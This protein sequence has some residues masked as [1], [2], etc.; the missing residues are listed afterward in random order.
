MARGPPP[1]GSGE[2]EEEA[3]GGGKVN[4]AVGGQGGGVGGLG[5]LRVVSMGE[6]LPFAYRKSAWSGG[7]S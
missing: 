6:L 4:E 1:A 7:S 5:S 3:V 2:E